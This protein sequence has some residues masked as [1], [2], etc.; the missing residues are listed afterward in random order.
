M[1][2]NPWLEE[3][4]ALSTECQLPTLPMMPTSAPE[5]HVGNFDHVGIR[6]RDKKTPLDPF[7]DLPPNDIRCKAEWRRWHSLLIKHYLD[8]HHPETE[9]AT[10]AYGRLITLWHERYGKRPDAHTCAGCNK[11]IDRS[12]LLALPEGA[13][14]HDNADPNCLKLYGTRWRTTAESALHAMGITNPDV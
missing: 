12:N 3:F 8:L 10:L 9:V 4:K 7:A 13:R 1:S 2:A 14:V 11:P 6:H 5:P